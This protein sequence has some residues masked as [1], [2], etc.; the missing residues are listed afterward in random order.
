MTKRPPKSKA[1]K[2]GP[3]GGRALQ[4]VRQ[5]EEARGFAPVHDGFERTD[6]ENEN[7][8]KRKRSR[9]ESKRPAERGRE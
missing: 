6:K 1:D 5:F 4:R 3:P 2:I 7:D 8:K 9:K